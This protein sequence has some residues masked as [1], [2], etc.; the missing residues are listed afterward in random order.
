MTSLVTRVEPV[1][2][3]E[4]YAQLLALE[5]RM[6]LFGGDA[7]SGSSVGSSANLASRGDVVVVAIV[8]MATTAAMVKGVAM[9]STT[10]SSPTRRAKVPTPVV[11]LGD[12]ATH[13]TTTPTTPEIVRSARSASRP[14]ILMTDV[15]I[16]LMKTVCQRKGTLLQRPNPHLPRV[17]CQ[18][19]WETA[20]VDEST[21]AR[22]SSVATGS[23]AATPETSTSTA[24][25]PAIPSSPVPARA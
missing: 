6:E 25:S 13:R 23:V 14:G 11:A 9:A 22:G 4:M 12:P 1:S 21:P 5:T 20:G 24:S 16:N 17:W 10:P 18:I 15:G 2:V 3:S 8:A 19:Q 7:N